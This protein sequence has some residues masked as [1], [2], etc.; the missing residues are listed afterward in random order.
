MKEIELISALKE[1]MESGVSDATIDDIL[2][3]AIKAHRQKQ[4]KSAGNEE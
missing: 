2:D 1:G 3:E 4:T